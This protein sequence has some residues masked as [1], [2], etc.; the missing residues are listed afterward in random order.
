MNTKTNWEER[1]YERS[2]FLP[3]KGR[4]GTYRFD[5]RFPSDYPRNLQAFNIQGGWADCPNVSVGVRIQNENEIF[6]E[7]T[8]DWSRYTIDKFNCKRCGRIQNLT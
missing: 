8:H 4:G 3:D 2:P 1:S 5:G 7:C 6:A